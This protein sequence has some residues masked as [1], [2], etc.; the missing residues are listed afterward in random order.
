MEH[1]NWSTILR[2]SEDSLREE[3]Y[4]G[5]VSKGILMARTH[6]TTAVFNSIKIVV[7]TIDD[8]AI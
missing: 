5:N 8:R 7:T 1:Q 3:E 2:I 6:F 4:P